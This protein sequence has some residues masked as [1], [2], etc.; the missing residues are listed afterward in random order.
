MADE[1]KNNAP[2][3]DAKDPSSPE[4]QFLEEVGLHAVE[5]EG[6]DRA[7]EADGRD[8]IDRRG[9][10]GEED[11]TVAVPDNDAPSQPQGIYCLCA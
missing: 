3:E 5:D 7:E 11:A 6:Q 2:A 1:E 8:D 10:D 4:P 9:S